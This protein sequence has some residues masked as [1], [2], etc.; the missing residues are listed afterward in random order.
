[1][2]EEFKHL[3][4]LM[5]A[6]IKG[7]KNISYAL[8]R[9]K[10]VGINFANTICNV[11]NIEKTK[12]AGD[13]TQEELTKIED[14]IKNPKKYNF[15]DYLLNRQKDYT[16]GENRHITSTDLKFEKEFDIKRLQKI[17]SFR[18]LR[19]SWGLPV[20]G[21]RTKNN[22]RKS[23]KAVGVMKKTVKAQQA[24]KGSDKK[25]DKKGDKK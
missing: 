21:Q 16:S 9:I 8:R 7:E 11:A 17:K 14:I 22:F 13:L 3:I 18:G 24:K 1:M 2:K 25:R 6:D 19:L 12:K 15:P 23:G 20:R 4:R 10:G 5:N